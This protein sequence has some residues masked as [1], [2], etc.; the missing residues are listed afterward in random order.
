MSWLLKEE[1]E[2]ETDSQPDRQRQRGTERDRETERGEWRIGD[3]VVAVG[4]GGRQRGRR[5]TVGGWD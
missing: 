1:R 4:G 5:R 2:L 3:E